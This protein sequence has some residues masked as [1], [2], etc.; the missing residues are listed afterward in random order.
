MQEVRIIA[1]SWQNKSPNNVF[2]GFFGCFGP[3]FGAFP[4]KPVFSRF[5]Q[6]QVVKKKGSEYEARASGQR[7]ASCS[8]RLTTLLDEPAVPLSRL[9]AGRQ[10]AA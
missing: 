8:R 9:A 10:A 4:K 3:G 1:I 2:C 6:A 7:R 5:L